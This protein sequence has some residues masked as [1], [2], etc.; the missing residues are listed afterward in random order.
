[1]I[2]DWKNKL[3]DKVKGAIFEDEEVEKQTPSPQV[4]VSSTPEQISIASPEV[5]VN[6]D[7]L[8]K[9]ETK[10][11][12]AD[13][14]GPDYLELKKAAEEPSLVKDEPDEGKRWRQAYRNMKVFFPQAEITK[15]KILGAIDHYIGIVNREEAIGMEQLEEIRGK[16]VNGE[17]EIVDSLAGEIL[18]LEKKILEK[19]AEKESRE[20]KILANRRKYDSQELSFKR[21]IGFARDILEKD[22]TRVTN[23]IEN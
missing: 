16:E 3:V 2:M 17:Q 14:P 11:Q 12:E 4:V 5:S 20:Q 9:I 21:T 13:L 19:K 6:R 15:V 23:Y 10:I 1:M 18:E 8:D 22:K 7:L